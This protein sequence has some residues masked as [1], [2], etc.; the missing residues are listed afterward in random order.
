[1][2]LMTGAL[3][4]AVAISQGKK[5]PAITDAARKAGMAQAPAVVQLAG[6]TCPVSDARLIGEDKKSKTSYFEVACAPGTMG[7]VLQKPAEGAVVAYSCIEANTPPAPG[8]PPSAPCF[9]SRNSHALRIV[10]LSSGSPTSASV[11]PCSI[12]RL[13]P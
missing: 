4:P 11:S 12:S 6:L 5:A 3:V 7:Y 1:M 8:Q 2:T 13:M 9:D 10:G